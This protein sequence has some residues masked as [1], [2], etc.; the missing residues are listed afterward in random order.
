MSIGDPGIGRGADAAAGS[1]RPRRAPRIDA[2]G[3]IGAW[4][5]H[6]RRAPFRKLVI[7][8]DVTA[9]FE[10]ESGLVQDVADSLEDVLDKPDGIEVVTTQRS[11]RPARTTPGRA[12]S[13]SVL[14]SAQLATSAPDVDRVHVLFL[15]G[16]DGGDG[17]V[18]GSAWDHLH[19]AIF[20]QSL[21]SQCDRVLATSSSGLCRGAELTVLLHELGHVIGLT[22]DGVPMVS[23]HR[24]RA[25]GHHD[26]DPR[27]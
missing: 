12:P 2:G 16:R 18:L 13:S 20:K 27:R 4:E 1:R 22:D 14:G 15:D 10:P 8:V 3:E 26:V 11:S 17:V 5:A 7:E 24:D 9:G 6:I 21:K 25:H 23:D 19:V